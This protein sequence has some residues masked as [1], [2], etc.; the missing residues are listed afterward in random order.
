MRRER[1]YLLR[2]WALGLVTGLVCV[3]VAHAAPDSPGQIKRAVVKAFAAS[4]AENDSL[5]ASA[6]LRAFDL[7]GTAQ[8]PALPPIAAPQGA[9]TPQFERFD[10]RLVLGMLAQAF[11]YKDNTNV[12]DAQRGDTKRALLIRDGAARLSD[13]PDSHVTRNGAT[14]TLHAPLVLWNK[15]ELYIGPG[16]T[17][18]LDGE[19]GAFILN[20]GRLSVDG[21]HIASNRLPN[22]GNADFNPFIT[23]TGAGVIRAANSR[24]SDLGFG[25]T[26]K[27]SGLSIARNALERPKDRSY[28]IDS[29]LDGLES[30]ILHAADGTVIAGN[31]I[32][33]PG[34]A[35]LLVLRS[36]AAEILDNVI[37]GEM[38]TNAIRVVDGSVGTRVEGNAILGGDRAGIL[39]KGASNNAIV[40]NNIVWARDGGGIKL[41]SIRCG[42]VTGNIVIDNRQK[43][44]EIR[45]SRAAIL[46]GNL[47]ASNKSA[48]IW[49][50]GQPAEAITRV[51]DN[52]LD[53]NGSG[54]AT[55]TAEAIVFEGNDFSHQF[56]Q[57]L[58]GDLVAQAR[59]VAADMTGETPIALSA[60][61]PVSVSGLPFDCGGGG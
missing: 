26:I 33:T 19:G 56:P 39:I 9:Q 16:E 24:F 51:E 1:A 17:L 10:M 31:R 23:T 48:G 20:L 44:I 34:K 49:I 11:G 45:R 28:I 57:F 12:I 25:G 3:T 8:R 13:L 30:L 50:S 27:F 46:S 29:H 7:G 60:S 54:V 14:T 41:D 59:Y 47:L 52:I 58:A 22:P 42:R 35:A 2:R 36:R 21:A 5:S 37:S 43:G 4:V 18:V 6:L 55:A 61:G 40:R 15:A 32:D 53:A 38:N